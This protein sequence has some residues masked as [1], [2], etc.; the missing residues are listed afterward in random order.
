[1]LFLPYFFYK[2]WCI[3]VNKKDIR[4]TTWII[5]V[6]SILYGITS[7]GL[8]LKSNFYGHYSESPCE[9]IYYIPF[10]LLIVFGIMKVIGLSTKKALIRRVSMVGLMFSWGFIWTADLVSFFAVGPN[11]GAILAIPILAIC[12]YLAMRGDYVDE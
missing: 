2:R 9:Y 5:S 4:F 7:I 11:R 12:T 6:T 10:L 3:L 8:L 1:M